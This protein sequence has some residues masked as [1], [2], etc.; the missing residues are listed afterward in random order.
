MSKA[1]T[2]K[3]KEIQRLAPPDSWFNSYFEAWNKYL[4]D[5]VAAYFF[6]NGFIESFIENTLKYFESY[7][8]F[9][10]SRID[11]YLTICCCY[12]HASR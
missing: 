3:S 5:L 9:Y 2:E 8:A 6:E 4:E 11:M 1:I 12:G 10:K 7:L